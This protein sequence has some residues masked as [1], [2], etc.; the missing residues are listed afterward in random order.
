MSEIIVLGIS[1]SGIQPFQ[2]KILEECRLI[3]C[4]NRLAQQVDR[5]RQAIFPI[6]P[7]NEALT[8]IG[9]ELS[10]GSI[11]VLASGDPLFYGIGKLLLE[12]FGK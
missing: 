3:V 12:H 10:R 8:K 9:D 4:G 11:A 6:T 5:N 1:G 2:S 7:L